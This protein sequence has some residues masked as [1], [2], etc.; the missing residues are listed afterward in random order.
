MNGI[1]AAFRPAWGAG[2]YPASPW[3]GS[4]M[5][6]LEPARLTSPASAYRAKR[7]PHP[8]VALPF[9]GLE[10]RDSEESRSQV[11]KEG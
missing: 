5:S 8:K 10:M 2:R 11:R 6:S 9:D 3:N 1:P 4:P 7:A